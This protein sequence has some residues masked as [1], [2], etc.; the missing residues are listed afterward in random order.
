MGFTETAVGLAP[1]LGICRL[2]ELRLGQKNA[3]RHILEGTLFNDANTAE[4]L[5][6]LTCVAPDLDSA[7]QKALEACAKSLSLPPRAFGATK[8]LLNGRVV[9][10]LD[11]ASL[12]YFLESLMGDQFQ[13]T[14]GDIFKR[15]SAKKK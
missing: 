12:E 15:L 4:E 1:P 14:I 6:F 9:E 11:D 5:G 7:K 10:Y 8:T 3:N 13:E 2:A